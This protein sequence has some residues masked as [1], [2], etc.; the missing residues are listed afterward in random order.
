MSGLGEAG[1]EKA[2]LG[3]DGPLPGARKRD[4]RPERIMS[5]VAC[6]RDTYAPTQE[7]DKRGK[8]LGGTMPLNAG[9]FQLQR[10]RTAQGPKVRAKQKAKARES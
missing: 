7:Y 2:T 9:F 4:P 5:R 3:G 6:F 1:S 8:H 10:M